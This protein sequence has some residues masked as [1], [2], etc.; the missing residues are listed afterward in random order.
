MSEEPGAAVPRGDADPVEAAVRDALR[1]G[2]G[3]AEVAELAGAQEAIAS[4]E[5]RPGLVKTFPPR[6]ELVVTPAGGG[7]TRTFDLVEEVDGRLSFGGSHP[8]EDPGRYDP[9]TPP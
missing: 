8:A 5:V 6:V 9:E 7:P 1:P 4:A 3:A 2:P